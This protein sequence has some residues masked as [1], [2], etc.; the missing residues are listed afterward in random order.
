MS[1]SHKEGLVEKAA[2]IMMAMYGD[3]NIALNKE[4]VKRNLRGHK[5]KDLEDALRVLEGRKK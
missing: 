3:S 5:E 1:S 4:E 2:G